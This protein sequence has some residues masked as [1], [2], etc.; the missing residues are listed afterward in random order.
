MSGK[1]LK[2]PSPIPAV[3][4]LTSPELDAINRIRFSYPYNFTPL[5]PR[6]FDGTIERWSLSKFLDEQEFP[7]ARLDIVD[8]LGIESFEMSRFYANVDIERI[9][10]PGE[11]SAVTTAKVIA[12][13][14][15]IVECEFNYRF[16]LWCEDPPRILSVSQLAGD[17][18]IRSIRTQAKAWEKAKANDELNLYNHF[19]YAERNPVIGQAVQNAAINRWSSSKAPRGCKAALWQ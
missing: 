16:E 12:Y 9:H 6:L 18:L 5:A 8:R 11:L 1:V 3:R 13:L 4:Q 19:V 14:L 7:F 10:I 17:S 15:D 2:F